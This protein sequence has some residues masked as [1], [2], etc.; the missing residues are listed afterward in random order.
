MA[1]PETERAS[2]RRRNRRG[3]HRAAA[4]RPDRGA[5]PAHPFPW[6][7][8]QPAGCPRRPGR[9]G[10]T[11]AK[12]R[13]LGRPGLLSP[14]FRRQRHHLAGRN[15]SDAA[16]VDLRPRS[17]PGLDGNRRRR[18]GRRR[19]GRRGRQP[20][21]PRCALLRR[22]N[23]R[24]RPDV[25]V[26]PGRRRLQVRH[27]HLLVGERRSRLPAVHRLGHGP[28]NRRW[29]GELVGGGHGGRSR[30][31]VHGLRRG[32][33]VVDGRLGLGGG[34]RRRAGQPGCRPN[35]VD[36]RSARPG[37]RPGRRPF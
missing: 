13:H 32:H 5:Q 11:D 37:I 17:G 23:Q 18:R 30:L 9:S 4:A 6:A 31:E 27:D 1:S 29:R 2:R 14:D 35:L 33:A 12:R 22:Q 20:D 25:A 34:W 19:R 7:H 28:G 16:Q 36:G 15:G 26:G 24:R 21:T 10:G 3:D 8:V